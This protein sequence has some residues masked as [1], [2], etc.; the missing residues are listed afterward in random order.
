MFNSAMVLVLVLE[1]G[2]VAKSWEKK[3]FFRYL[4][5]WQNLA[6]NE[7]RIKHPSKVIFSTLSGTLHIVAEMVLN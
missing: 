7:G 5:E 4:S 6:F 2:L 1:K 3:F